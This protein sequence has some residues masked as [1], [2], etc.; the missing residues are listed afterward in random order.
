MERFDLAVVGG[1]PAGLATAIAAAR[2][3]L[4]AVV[5]EASSSVP[6]DKAC[7]EGLMPAGVRALARLGVDAQGLGRPFEGIRFLDGAVT[8]EGRFRQGSGVGVR[9]P[10][11]HAA[12]LEAAAAAGV[13]LR[14]GIRVQSID[15]ERGA[16]VAP[17]GRLE[18]RFVVG[19]DGLLSR[20]RRWAGL[21][22]AS[23]RATNLLRYG[24]RRHFRLAPWSDFVEVS[25]SEVGEAYVTPVADDEVGVAFLWSGRKA[26]FDD[27]LEFFP[28]LRER[29][30]GASV[31]S[32]A[33]GAGPLRQRA[34][35]VVRGRTLLVGDA[36]GYVDAI[37]GEG[38]ALAF[39]EALA[40]ATAMAS[41]DLA[42]YRAARRAIHRGPDTLTHLM[43]FAERRPALRRFVIRRLARSPALFARLLGV[44]SGPAADR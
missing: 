29:L 27:L 18:A 19:A 1:G 3:G 39:E 41:D 24:V 37:T 6:I 26:V 42:S 20:V 17:G 16:V 14:F 44:H 22:R 10:R 25:W 15:A 2:L 34:V 38:L 23:R 32:R 30:A 4:R 28:A 9:R 21:E 31:V 12:L 8:A 35:D 13:A 7:G 33:L 43:L 40:A 36:G 5:F 11:L